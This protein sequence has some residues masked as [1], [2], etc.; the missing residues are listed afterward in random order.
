MAARFVMEFVA[1]ILYAFFVGFCFCDG[2]RLHVLRKIAWFSAFLLTSV[3]VLKARDEFD[4]ALILP[5]PTLFALLLCG[6][7]ARKVREKR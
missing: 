2:F 1:L 7:E 5:V 6:I 3:I 4:L